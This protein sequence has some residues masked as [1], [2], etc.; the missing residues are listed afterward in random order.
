[1]VA[2]GL[3]LFELAAIVV[4]VVAVVGLFG[5]AYRRRVATPRFWRGLTVLYVAVGLALRAVSLVP[6]LL[7][8]LEALIEL[9]VR[10]PMYV[11]LWLYGTD[12]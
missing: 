11:G 7:G 12:D 5:F 1:M 4:E 9:G 8:V 3:T 10:V 6:E 2:D